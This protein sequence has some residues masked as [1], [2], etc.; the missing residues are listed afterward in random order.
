MDVLS[1]LRHSHVRAVGDHRQLALD[2]IAEIAQGRP[3]SGGHHLDAVVQELL[4]RHGF[5]LALL[6]L[7]ANYLSEFAFGVREGFAEV[8]S[9][10]NEPVLDPLKV[11]GCRRGCRLRRTAD[12]G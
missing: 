11:A 2:V 4:E 1:Q 10:T 7:I 3:E 5:L 8:L 6:D 9:G 12:G